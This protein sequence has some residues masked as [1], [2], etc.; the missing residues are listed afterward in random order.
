MNGLE[1]ASFIVSTLVGSIVAIVTLYYSFRLAN[2]YK[3]GMLERPWL[4]VVYGIALLS[5]WVI[6]LFINEIL[7]LR[8]EAVIYWIGVFG[9][10]FLL[11]G[12]RSQ[13]TLWEKGIG[14]G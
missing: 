13:L 5:L 9:G 12:V 4:Y 14:R 10:I 7:R 2:L 1:V 8:L 6:M 3:G 11:L